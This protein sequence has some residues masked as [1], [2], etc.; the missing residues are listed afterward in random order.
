MHAQRIAEHHDAA[1]WHL[2]AKKKKK[3]Q[4]GIQVREP[5]H[6]AAVPDFGVLRSH[7]G[8]RPCRSMELPHEQPLVG[9]HRIAC[10]LAIY[11][12]LSDWNWLVFASRRL[13]TYWI[14]E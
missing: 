14:R 12:Q 9:G 5:K 7:A 2:D 10:A 1:I 8:G 3:I 6:H 13:G 11:Q 4:E